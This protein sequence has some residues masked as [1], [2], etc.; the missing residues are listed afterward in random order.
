MQGEVV[1]AWLLNSKKVCVCVH[2]SKTHILHFTGYRK[3]I[4]SASTKL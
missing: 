4:W 2:M 3:I 1:R